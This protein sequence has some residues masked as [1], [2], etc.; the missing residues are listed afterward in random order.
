MHLAHKDTLCWNTAFTGAL[1]CMRK[2]KPI[3]KLFWGMRSANT[4]L[5]DAIADFSPPLL[6][7]MQPLESCASTVKSVA[8]A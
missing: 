2:A 4:L 5:K 6:P 8:A 1:H 3:Q 7:Y